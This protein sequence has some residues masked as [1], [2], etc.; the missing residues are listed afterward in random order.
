MKVKILL[1]LFVAAL[2]PMA[3]PQSD[4]GSSSIKPVGKRIC[5]TFDD[6]PAENTYE[7]ET[8]KEIFA[9]ITAALE[10][11]HVPAAGFVVGEN[12]EDN[13][14]LL[15]LWAG[16]G[17]TF[18]FLPYSNQDINDV[19]I[20][21]YIDDIDKGKDAV[22][23]LMAMNRQKERFFRFPFLRYG[24]T[25]EIRD[26][27]LDYLAGEDI[28]VAHATVLT[29]DFVYNLSLEKNLNILDSSKRA[30]LQREYVNHIISCLGKAEVLAKEVAGRP[31]LQIL[32]LHANRINGIFLEAVLTAIE[33]RGYRYISLGEALK[34]DIYGTKDTYYNEQYVSFLERIK[35]SNPDLI[36][37][38][39]K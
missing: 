11:H 29:E 14:D 6:I 31:V 34:D 2:S 25:K 15:T 37:A 5:I 20:E 7:K 35:Y 9:G 23:D 17:F 8:R 12:L 36:P 39:E 19:P 38:V 22:K 10:R 30:E 16:K 4:A 27:V 32:Q 13:L 33:K 21:A 24:G 18:G 1:L 26:Q 3:G 28:S